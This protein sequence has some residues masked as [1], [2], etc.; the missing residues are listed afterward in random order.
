MPIEIACECGR[1]YRAGDVL[2]GRRV[3]CKGCGAMIRVP[4]ALPEVEPP[5]E[6]DPF[7]NPPASYEVDGSVD[8]ASRPVEQ[9]ALSA[10][11]VDQF[12]T[13][14]NP[15]GVRIDF[16]HYLICHP[17]ELIIAGAGLVI[18]VGG[19]LLTMHWA[20]LIFVG[21]GVWLLVQ[22]LLSQR[23]KLIAGD[24]C[25][26]VVISV[27][28]YRVA[29]ATD[30][31]TGGPARPAILIK[32]ASLSRMTGGPAQLGQRLATVA[33]YAGVASEDAWRNFDPTVLACA[34]RN[35][36]DIARVTASIPQAQWRQLDAMLA[37]LPEHRVGLYKLWLGT[38]NQY[39]SGGKQ[40]LM[41]ALVLI[42]LAA[43][44]IAIV[45]NAV[46]K[47]KA[48]DVSDVRTETPTQRVV[49]PPRLTS[50]R[51]NLISR[52]DAHPAPVVGVI[53]EVKSSEPAESKPDA[54]SRA[55]QRIAEAK[56]EMEARRAA[57]RAQAIT[58]PAAA[59]V[60]P[61][62]APPRVG[63][64]AAGD[65]IEIWENRRNWKPGTV[66]KKEGRRYFVHYDGWSDSWDEWVGP[67]QVRERP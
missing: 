15:G 13:A 17:T 37:R 16:V 26:A 19:A 43:P 54:K 39:M 40:R 9:D 34:T 1:Q 50:P 44:V 20:P 33:L 23:A 4:V 28:P 31:T 66:L 41:G 3:K 48:A 49:T 22:G 29:V 65:K 58:A 10:M 36:A 67:D 6:E 47:N 45:A 35:E 60:E 30:L 56:A 59:E 38:Q 5:V 46:K 42:A 51:P 61:A 2:A 27:N 32:K 24:V 64:F 7:A 14:S 11:M 53:P 62:A 57:R 52:P 63:P 25:P 12:T 8:N 21:V 18:G 55:E